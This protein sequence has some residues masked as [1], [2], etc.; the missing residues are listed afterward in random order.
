V[1]WASRIG[2][3]GVEGLL[4]SGLGVEDKQNSNHFGFLFVEW[5]KHEVYRP[6]PRPSNELERCSSKG[7][8]WE[9]I[10]YQARVV[11]ASQ[12]FWH[13]ERTF[14]V[15]FHPPA[16]AGTVIA[17]ATGVLSELSTFSGYAMSFTVGSPTTCE[18]V[19]HPDHVQYLTRNWALTQLSPA[20][21]CRD[22]V[23]RLR[24][25]FQ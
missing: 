5:A 23:A 9:M 21:K 22:V 17:V 11:L 6:K 25:I 16:V 10:T 4:V 1:D 15:H 13:E 2:G 12:T 19:F 24:I 18:Q 14:W 8:N 3:L 7:R 20:W